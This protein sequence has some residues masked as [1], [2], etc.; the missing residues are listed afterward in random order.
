MFIAKRLPRLSLVIAT[1]TA[2][3]AHATNGLNQ[4]SYGSKAGGMGGASAAYDSRN[5]SLM[6]K[7]PTVKGCSGTQYRILFVLA[8]KGLCVISLVLAGLLFVFPCPALI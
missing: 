2:A 6:N 8:N 1:L 3:P 5:S 4:E 7:A